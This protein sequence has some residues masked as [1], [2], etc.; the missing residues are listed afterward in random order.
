MFTCW[1]EIM[2]TVGMLSYRMADS[3]CVMSEIEYF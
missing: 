1:Q 3:V 2:N